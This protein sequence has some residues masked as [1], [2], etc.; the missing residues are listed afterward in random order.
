LS[1]IV[2]FTKKYVAYGIEQKKRMT[3]KPSGNA[4]IV[5]QLRQFLERERYRIKNNLKSCNKMT[6]TFMKGMQNAKRKRLVQIMMLF[7]FLFLTGIGTANAHGGDSSETLKVQQSKSRI[8]GMVV[9][10]TGESVIGAN[11]VEKGVASNGTISDINGNF[12]LEVTPGATLTVSF[13]GYRTQEVATGTQTHINITLAEDTQTLEE[14]VVVG[15]GTQKKMTLTGSIATLSNQDLVKAPV[16][17]ISKAIVGRLPGV[18]V[19]DRGG[20]PG[21]DATVDIRGFGS[22]L[23]LVDGIQQS[24]FQIDPNEIESIS[25]LKDASAAIYGVKAGNGVM[26]ITTRKGTGGKAKITYNGAYGWQNLASYPEVINALEYAESMNEDALNRGMALIYTPEDLQK[27][28][29][30][31]EVG[32]RSYE[33]FN[34]ITRPNAPQTQHN[35]NVSGGNETFQ[36]FTSVGYVNQSSQYRENNAGFERYNVR[37]NISAQI[38]QYLTAEVQLSGRIEKRNLVKSGMNAVI[39]VLPIF[40]PWA[41][42]DNPAYFQ[43]TTFGVNH[44]ITLHPDLTGYNRESNKLFNGQF[45]LKYDVPFIE[46]LSAK[47]LF[48]YLG[49]LR[50]GKDFLKEHNLYT[51]DRSTDTYAVSYTANSPSSLT[52]RD[53]IGEQ[54]FLQF[55]LDYNRTFAQRHT[56]SAFVAYEQREDRSNYLS[57]YR[58]FDIDALDQIN[59]GRDL[60]KTNEGS[61]SEAAN[62]SFIGR[63]N[64]DYLSRY[65]INLTFR[66][67]GS[68]KFH[69]DSRWGFFPGVELAWRISEE[70]FLKDRFTDLSNLKLRLSY[71]KTGD[72]EV[73]AFQYLTGYTYPA[74]TSYIFGSDV[75]R[76]LISKGLPNEQFTWYTSEIFNAGIDAAYRNGLLEASLDVFYRKRDGLLATRIESLPNTFGASLPQENLNSDDYRG[77]E[78]TLGHRHQVQDF[79]Y[80]VRGNMS[81]TRSRNRYIEQNDPI[82][83]FLYWRDNRSYR[84]NNLTYGYVCVGQFN[85][86]EDI[87]T[88]AVQ[89]GA[90]NTTLLPGDLKFKDLDGDGV[91]NDRDIQPIGRSNTPE[92][93]YG[94]DLTAAWKGFDLSVLL[95]GATHYS[96][97]MTNAAAYP[98]FNSGTS[99]KILM[100]RWHRVDPFDANSDWIPGKYPSTYATGKANNTRVST[101]Y[102]LNSYY[103]RVKNVELG[104]TLP[105]A[106][107]HKAGI[108]NLRFYVSGNNVLTF[109]NLPYGDP[110]AASATGFGYPSIK[111]WNMGV[112]ITF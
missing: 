5:F 90:G 22:P 82:N 80:S 73:N 14:V 36:Y 71:G 60:N 99:L 96:R 62:V 41:N 33:W 75:V 32:Y 16:S 7:T 2:P 85:N 86:Q 92:I 55:R 101:F 79:R 93:Y 29:E 50:E 42:D 81:F 38:A 72:D 45:S 49:N 56:I 69:R 23:I 15:Y 30:G 88:W 27:F 111:I 66:E 9:D 54:N 13:I 108:N 89:D 1:R 48:S 12:T 11:I 102:N 97:H 18:R 52:R 57:A 77:F 51:Y 53:D 67:D 26:L 63:L 68:A 87:N 106:W 10:Q 44:A 39:Q 37:S 105:K 70:S 65:M 17:T 4:D 34:I 59:A 61:Q 25:I 3:V 100:D 46:G 6:T 47:A 112:N 107:I 19:V 76:G 35:L 110:E 78:L 58:Q 74:G 40:S 43:R 64:Y 21:S 8:T 84:W 104:Y 31:T 83:S 94:I 95:Q 109:D 98:L 20:D 103:A 24:G 28:R 91:I